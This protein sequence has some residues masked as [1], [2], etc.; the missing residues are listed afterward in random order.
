[1]KTFFA[2]F[3]A[4][5]CFFLIAQKPLSPNLMLG[6]GFGE[7]EGVGAIMPNKSHQLQFSYQFPFS[8]RIGLK[9]GVAETVQYIN[10]ELVSDCWVGTRYYKYKGFYSSFSIPTLLT[11]NFHHKETHK[12]NYFVNTGLVFNYRWVENMRLYDLQDVETKSVY[13]IKPSEGL[14]TN[15]A[16]EIGVR[17]WFLHEYF[18]ELAAFTCNSLDFANPNGYYGKANFTFSLGK[19]L[20]KKEKIKS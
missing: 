10:V 2:F 19:S 16:L 3:C 9:T 11:F 4:F 6:Y 12:M 17:R 14:T 1:M 5:S 7:E 13:L 8:K 20:G 15:F 18:M